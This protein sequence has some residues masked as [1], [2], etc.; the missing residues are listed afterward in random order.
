LPVDQLRHDARRGF[1]APFGI[2]VDGSG[3]IY[4][5]DVTTGAVYEM[6][7]GCFSAGCVTTLAG[8]FPF[9]LPEDVAVDGAGNVFVP[10]S[11]IDAVYEMPPG[12][13]SAS[14][15]I[16]I[17]SGSPFSFPTGVAVDGSGD[18][19]VADTGIGATTAG[20]VFEILSPPPQTVPALGMGGKLLCALLLGAAGYQTIRRRAA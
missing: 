8:T 17:A 10:D 18:I 20:S 9:I 7:P 3:N 4:V 6:P 15:V 16:T 1:G 5:A 11:N 13:M 14:C 2:A 19:F 12:C